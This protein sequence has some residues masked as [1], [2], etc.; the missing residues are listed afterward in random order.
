MIGTEVV[1]YKAALK[2]KSCFS[3]AKRVD[4]DGLVCNGNNKRKSLP[5]ELDRKYYIFERSKS[6]SGMENPMGTLTFAKLKTPFKKQ[7]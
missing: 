5:K 4:I 2:F 3:D 1:I 7:G 6:L